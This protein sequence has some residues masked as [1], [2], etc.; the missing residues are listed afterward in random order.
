MSQCPHAC[1]AG[2]MIPLRIPLR[3]E[4]FYT[5][6]MTGSRRRGTIVRKC[7]FYQTPLIWEEKKEKRENQKGKWNWRPPRRH[8]RIH[9]RGLS[10]ILMRSFAQEIH[11]RE[12]DVHHRRDP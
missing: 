4:M 5:E 1:F 2:S 12:N 6:M 10:R 9:N 7:P 8:V 3:R 11:V